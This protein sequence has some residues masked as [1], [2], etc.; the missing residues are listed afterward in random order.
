V[1]FDVCRCCATIGAVVRF[2]MDVTAVD[3]PAASRLRGRLPPLLARQEPPR[4]HQVPLGERRSCRRGRAV[5]GCELARARGLGHVR[6]RL[7]GHA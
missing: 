4:A 7:D 2:L 6:R 5:V 3:Y 1:L